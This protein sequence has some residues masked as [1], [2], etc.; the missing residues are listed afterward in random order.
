[1]NFL[2]QVPVVTIYFYCIY[3]ILDYY[4]GKWTRHRK[5]DYLLRISARINGIWQ[6]QMFIYGADNKD[7]VIALMYLKCIL[8][9]VYNLIGNLACCFSHTDLWS[10]AWY[11]RCLATET[12]TSCWQACCYGDVNIDPTTRHLDPHCSFTEGHF[13]ILC[14]LR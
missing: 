6:R 7:I 2:K 9:L 1:M 3:F 14:F 4:E 13:F 11:L 12:D 10:A 5:R 8:N